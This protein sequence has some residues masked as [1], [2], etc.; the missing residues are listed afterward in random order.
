ML[1]AGLDVTQAVKRQGRGI[2]RYIRQVVPP[3][4]ALDIEP[5]L[6]IR[7]HRWFARSQVADLAPGAP[8]AWMPRASRLPQRPLDL[9][10][11]FGNHLPRPG[12]V[13]LAFTVHDVR[14]LD[15]PAGYEGRERL[16]RNLG[17][18]AGVLCLT[19]YGRTRL[20]H[21]CPE[22]GQRPL[23]VVPHGVD[24]AAFR[25]QDPQRAAAVAARYGLR[26]PF[27]LQLGSW[28]PHKNLELSIHALARS[29]ARAEG[30]TLAFVGG[31]APRGYRRRLEDLARGEG[32]AERLVWV[33]HVPG[34]DL[35]ALIGAA[36][37]LLQPSRYEGFALPLLE[38]MA[39]GTPGVA[40]DASCLPEVSAGH[41]P[42]ADPDD[43]EAFA[44]GI[45]R[46][47]LDAEAR[48]ATVAAGR[49]HAGRFTWQRTA[50][51]TLAFWQRLAAR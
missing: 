4:A 15:R 5:T 51:Q 19:E 42:L 29:R 40:A 48:A 1:K 31:G 28:F 3:L 24:H 49:T 33:D 8:R 23:A 35:P 47:T 14:A 17:R 43:P 16:L 6:C 38:A 39:V 36:A 44:A 7:G 50:A 10:H 27:L 13:P 21:H 12:G 37:A 45:D 30:Y 9:F 32:V 2:A 18:A 25:P 26:P 34:P 46:V 20:L 41:W 11:G 22:L